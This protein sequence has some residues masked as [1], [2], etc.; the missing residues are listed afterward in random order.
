MTFDSTISRSRSLPSRVRSP[1]PAKTEKPERA[2]AMLLISSITIDCLADAGAA[3]QTNLAA[4]HKRLKSSRMT[5]IPV[6]NILQLSRLF[7]E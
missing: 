6:S 5:L 7:F 3:K 2:L 4:A 1:T